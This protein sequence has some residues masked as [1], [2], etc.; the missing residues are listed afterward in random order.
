MA[1]Y[2]E[3]ADE[4][5][6]RIL[7]G[8]YPAES[9][10]PDQNTLADQ[11]GVSRMTIKKALDIIATEGLIYRQRGSGTYV[12]KTALLGNRDGY[13]KEYE[14]L[15]KQFQGKNIKSKVI[16]FDIEFPD[17]E[18][19]SMLMIETNSPVYKIVRQR[20]V[21]END[22][23]ILEYTYFAAE[24]I[25]GLSEEHAKNS[26]YTYIQKELGLS[27][28]GAFRK[29][30]ADKSNKLDHEYLD[31]KEHDPVLEVEQIVYLKNG[32]PFEYSRSRN[33]FDTR[34]YTMVDVQ[35]DN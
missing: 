7:D 15:T 9:L 33:R 31:C 32:K 28:G 5:R 24:L 3:I 6:R 2:K 18:L 14:G 26:I 22:L 30:H 34:S 4:V 35:R 23:K 1:R 16:Q 20:V 21:E 25:P 19:A 17:E 13:L 10:I 11:F 27:F 8:E 29:I 12:M